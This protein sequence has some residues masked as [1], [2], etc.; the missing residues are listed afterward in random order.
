L[1]SVSFP[2]ASQIVKYAFASTALT[3]VSFPKVMVISEGAFRECNSLISVSFPWV[4]L[5]GEDAIRNCPALTSVS[6][7]SEPG[8]H[9]ELDTHIGELAFG[10]CDA[11]TSVTMRKSLSLENFNNLRS[12]ALSPCG[13]RAYSR[14]KQVFTP[15]SS[16]YTRLLRGTRFIRAVYSARRSSDFSQ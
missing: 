12:P 2:N 3:N 4:Y 15:L 7:Q 1:T 9:L 6:I 16:A 5:I 13:A 10:N 14:G 8:S 11:L